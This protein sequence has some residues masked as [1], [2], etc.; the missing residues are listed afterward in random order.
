MLAD[1]I[2]SKNKLDLKLYNYALEINRE[3]RK[4]LRGFWPR[5]ARTWLK[6]TALFFNK[7]THRD[8]M[9]TQG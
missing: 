6:Q 5:V 8:F 9:A 3:Q 7:P 1:K 4:R 2:F